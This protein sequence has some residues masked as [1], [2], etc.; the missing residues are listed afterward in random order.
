[1]RKLVRFAFMGLPCLLASCA[2]TSGNLERAT[3]MSI[4][5]NV[6]PENVTVSE[7]KRGATSVTWSAV[8]PLGPYAC[9]ADDMVRRP[10][11][12]KH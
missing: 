10:Y 7:V 1:M 8:T 9:S 4:G 12:V 6:A 5:H 3:A 2:S 11:C